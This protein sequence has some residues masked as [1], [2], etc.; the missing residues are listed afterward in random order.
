MSTILITG[1]AGFIAHHTIK[2]ILDE[3]DWNIVSLDRLDFSGNLNRLYDML[4][5]HN[6]KHRVKIVYHDLK[7]EINQ[8]TSNLIGNVDYILHMAA[9]PHVDK[10]IKD[11]LSTVLDNVVGTCNILNFART[12]MPSLKRFIYFS[13]DEVFGPCPPNVDFTEYSRY[14]S[15]NPYSASKAGGEELSVAF[16]NTYKLPVYIIHSMNVFG[17]RQQTAAFIPI[18]IRKILKDE[19][20][21]IH[22]DHTLTKIPTRKYVH[23]LDVAD[24][25][26]LLLQ[27][28][29]TSIDEDLPKVP[30]FNIAGMEKIDILTIANTIAECIGKPLKYKVS[31]SDRPGTDLDYSLAGPRL[32]NLGWYPKIPFK[33]SIP[34]IVDWYLKNREWI[35]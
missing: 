20:L 16:H 27:T 7:A 21:T 14:N 30:K 2:R 25:V 9:N 23:A 24:A 28:D 26:L 33:E 1:G 10:S 29:T 6:Q 4:K 19:V 13:T 35:D 3:T 22:S 8:T 34:S 5:D 11:P 12:Q 18:C 32:Q 31:S 15:K 17:E